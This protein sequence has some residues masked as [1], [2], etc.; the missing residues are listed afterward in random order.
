V[1][2]L[3]LSPRR[4]INFCKCARTKVRQDMSSGKQRWQEGGSTAAKLIGEIS[5]LEKHA[6]WLLTLI[7]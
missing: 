6:D 4:C 5:P 7:S 3:P 1:K 2:R